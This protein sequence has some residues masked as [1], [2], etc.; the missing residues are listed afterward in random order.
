M[1]GA[2]GFV[3]IFQESRLYTTRTVVT[4]AS[5]GVTESGTLPAANIFGRNI[6]KPL[7][8]TGVDAG[9]TVRVDIRIV[10][11]Q[12]DKLTN[13]PMGAGVLGL[14]NVSL[15]SG[16]TI[17]GAFGIEA[18]CNAG[19]FSDAG[20]SLGSAAMYQTEFSPRNAFFLLS[21]LSDATE[22]KIGGRSDTGGRA[23]NSYLRIIF[24]GFTGAGME[25]DIGR[26]VLMPLI[27]TNTEAASYSQGASDPSEIVNAFDG[28]PYALARR[29][30]REVGFSFTNLGEGQVI[31]D[32]VSTMACV[33]QANYFAG[34]HDSVVLVPE[35]SDGQVFGSQ[36]PTPVFGMLRAPL[37]ATLL[38]PGSYANR[39]WSASGE[40]REILP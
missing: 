39:I 17:A 30:S 10:R 20:T 26:V 2:L 34:A 38:K 35:F 11:A 27:G 33:R 16:G 36:D 19:A 5:S 32:G 18:T 9:D 29:G 13:L 23:F 14:L 1:A 6:G 37:A 31:G 15:R 3:D 24:D 22:K 28:T 8:F 21:D 4:T 25:L 7:R 12:I 40:V